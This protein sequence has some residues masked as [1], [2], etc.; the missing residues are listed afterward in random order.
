[1][2]SKVTR[3]EIAINGDEWTISDNNM[4]VLD[5]T[6]LSLTD[7]DI[8]T[9]GQGIFIDGAI[10]EDPEEELQVAFQ[11]WKLENFDPLINNEKL[12]IDGI[13][14]GN[15]SFSNYYANPTVL[16]NLALKELILNGEF[17]DQAILKSG[18]SSGDSVLIIDA[19]VFH[20]DG[21]DTSTTLKAYGRYDPDHPTDNLDFDIGVDHIPLH[22]FEPFVNAVFSDIQ[23]A[24]EGSLLLKG[25][26]SEP[27]LTGSLWAR[28]TYFY[29]SYTNVKYL[30]EHEVFFDE[31]LISFEN[32]HVYDTLGNEGIAF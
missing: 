4:V 12:D 8:R 19:E 32:V 6:Y 26:L 17:M 30:L 18:W 3:L 22:A 24:V 11:D 16:A 27:V 31:N 7:I 2:E 21:S 10:S 13:I 20:A 25:S 1:M 29:I 28:H 14:N 9:M 5:S 23:G 15:F